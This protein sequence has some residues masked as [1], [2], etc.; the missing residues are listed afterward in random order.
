MG[1][2]CPRVSA[3]PRPWRVGDP[4]PH[5]GRRFL[6]LDLRREPGP[7]VS[8]TRLMPTDPIL[9]AA[10]VGGAYAYLWVP[11][12]VRSRRSDRTNPPPVIQTN[13]STRSTRHRCGIG[14]NDGAAFPFLLVALYLWL[15][16]AVLRHVTLNVPSPHLA[17]GFAQ[18]SRLAPFSPGSRRGGS[19][20]RAQCSSRLCV[21]LF[22]KIWRE[23]AVDR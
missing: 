14:C 7:P 23:E 5:H 9:A 20:N 22:D 12:V 18:R 6:R 21:P 2:S 3:V 13:S 4:R 19:W 16:G 11:P 17:T 8:A 10:V 15:S 1:G